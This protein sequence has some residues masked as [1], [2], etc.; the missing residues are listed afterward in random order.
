[1]N[2]QLLNDLAELEEIVQLTFRGEKRRKYIQM[3][4]NY[5]T[6]PNPLSASIKLDMLLS[7]LRYEA[8][9]MEAR[10]DPIAPP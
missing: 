8:A 1:M 2:R 10:R 5:I 6:D 4:Y 3:L 9:L 7:N